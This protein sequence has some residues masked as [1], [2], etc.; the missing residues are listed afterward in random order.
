M[1]QKTKIRTLSAMIIGI[2]LAGCTTTGSQMPDPVAAQ[3]PAQIA[4]NSTDP[5]E[6]FPVPELDPAKVEPR[7]MRQLVDYSTREPPGTIVIDTRQRFI[8]VVQESGKALRYGVGVG[9][10]GLEF[11]GSAV[12]GLK[13]EWPRWTPTPTM[14]QREPARYRSWAAGMAG[15]P[16]NPL[17]ARALYL[18]KNGR[19]TLFRIHGTNEPE[20]IGHAVSS[21]CIRMMNQDVIDLYRRVPAGARVVVL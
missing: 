13:R 7:N 12:V 9:R 16:E 2:A 3:A 21:G 8:F 15:G 17:G 11:T 4:S 14:I 1:L 5:N 20:T 18:Y 19:D 10:E 6:R